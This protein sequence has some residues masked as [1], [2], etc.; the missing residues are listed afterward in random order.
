MY[1]KYIKRIFDFIF[2]FIAF[3]IISPVLI[4]SAILIKLTSKGPVFYFQKRLGMNEKLFDIFKF[5]TMTDVDRKVHKAVYKDNAEVTKVGKVLRRFKIDEL[6]QIINVLKGDMAI[7][8]PR[9]CL[10]QTRSKFD[11][12]TPYRF[13]V[14]PGLT[15]NAAVNGGI[16]LSWPEKWTYDRFYAENVSFIMDLKII[17]KTILVVFFGEDKFIKKPQG[18]IS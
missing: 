10:E 12:N 14:R 16:Y 6:P 13:E 11:E 8:G 9:P 18:F 7:V 1:K 4:I 15:S 3:I 17:C 2:A 5:R